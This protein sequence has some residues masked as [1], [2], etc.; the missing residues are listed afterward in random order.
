MREPTTFQW[1][2][3]NAPVSLV[4]NLTMLASIWFWY[5]GQ[6][7][8]WLTVAVIAVAS[9]S[10]R[11]SE[12]VSRYTAWK[13]EWDGAARKDFQLPS[14][15][16]S[17]YV[18]AVGAWVALAFMAMGSHGGD[19]ALQFAGGL[20]WFGSAIAGAATIIGLA[21]RG[22]RA[23]VNTDN[24]TV[25]VGRKFASPTVI[26]AQQSLPWN[27]RALIEGCE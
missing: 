17:K 24:V 2:V 14:M 10:H 16:G 20:F 5:V 19:K 23:R 21:R 12:R 11:A 15:P 6:L 13:R 7:N 27:V 3:G 25:C 1:L 4:V 18:L 22:W 26:G 8:G 9:V